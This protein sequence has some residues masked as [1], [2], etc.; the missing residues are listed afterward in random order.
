MKKMIS[1]VMVCI[2]LLSVM[3]GCSKGKVK[4]SDNSNKGSEVMGRY[5]EED[6]EFPA[7][8]A[9]DKYISLTST[10]DG[11]LE[12]YVYN[13]TEYEKYV[14]IDRQW[15]RENADGLKKF[16]NWASD[17]WITDIFYGEDGRQYLFGNTMKYHNALYRLSDNGEY[18]KIAIPK[19]EEINEAWDTVYRAKLIKVLKNGMI[20][21]IYH[22][23]EIEVYSSDGQSVVG[24]FSSTYTGKIAVEGNYLYYTDQAGNELIEHNL[25][26]DK[27]EASWPIDIELSDTGI[28]ESD[29]TAAYLCDPTG[30]HLINKGGSIWETIM[31]GNQ[32]SLAM[33]TAVF[34]KFLTGTEK[35]FYLVMKDN[36]T[37]VI[38]YYFYDENASTVPEIELSIFSLEENKT[39][40][41]AIAVFYESHPDVKINYRVAKV[42]QKAFY[43]YGI[44][45]P[46]QTI[47]QTD[48]IKTL[49]TELLAGKGPDILVLDGISIDSYIEKGILEDM[50]DI[51][52][53]MI[54]SGDLLGNIANN[55]IEDGRVYAIPARFKI[56]IIYGKAEAVNSAKSIEELVA[57]AQDSTEIPLL[58]PSSY[59]SLAAYFLLLY[60]DHIVSEKKEIDGVLLQSFMEHIHELSVHIDAS[61][62]AQM[63]FRNISSGKIVGGYWMMGDINVHKKILQA[64]IG[65]MGDIKDF[66][67]PL[68]ATAQWSGEYKAINNTYEANTLVGI[69]STGSQKELAREFVQLLL[70]E[71]IQGLMGMEGFPI[72]QTALE[73]WIQQEPKD[74]I[75]MLYTDGDYEI[76]GSYPKLTIREKIYEMISTLSKSMV[77]DTT[78]MD[79]ILDETERYLRGDISAEQA[80]D[81][82]VSSINTYLNE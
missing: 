19:F 50:G 30:I 65:V 51:I 69:N 59:R 71:E 10:P 79:M 58:G 1:V 56:P 5:V 37:A 66:M 43:D 44:G 32:S 15:N 76:R 28:L 81:N 20:A 11:N 53:P 42:N 60:S 34:I 24:E 63:S 68:E 23:G 12:L 3:S 82:A 14:Y 55:Y 70:A 54:E 38:K 4:D 2:I 17:F 29:Q 26:T 48:Y 25:E 22:N 80:A 62:D 39:I 36:S 33:P 49:N 45:D 74:K 72:N 67:V 57:Y 64:N 75:G 18:E 6:I 27:Q 73:Q 46:K 8:V 47:T 7:G 78:M 16:Y 35:D 40:R 21:A 61:D 9:A 52:I 31:D 13:Y 77:N 41:Q